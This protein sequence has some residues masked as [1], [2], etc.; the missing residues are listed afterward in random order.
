MSDL[1]SQITADLKKQIES[2]QPE[3]EVADVGTVIEAGDGIAR[4][5]GLAD[6]RAQELVQFANGVMG[7]A[8]NL[9]RRTLASSS[10]AIILKLKRVWKCALPGALL[11]CRS[12]MA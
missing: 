4:V 2:Y 9:E 3:M 10:W 5:K 11:L 7:I 1:I 6:V 12:A 8:F